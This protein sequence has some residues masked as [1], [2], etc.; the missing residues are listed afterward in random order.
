[1]D[2]TIDLDEELPA[3]A[4]PMVEVAPRYLTGSDAKRVAQVIFGSDAAFYEQRPSL[5]DEEIFS[6]AEI[7]AK[8]E[9]WQTW[10]DVDYLT[11]LFGDDEAAQRDAELVKL[12]IDDYTERYASAPE[13]DLRV[14][15][16]WTLKTDSAYLYDDAQLETWDTSED[17]MSIQAEVE[18]DGIPYRFTV[19][20]RD[21]ADFQLNNIYAAI[22]D[23]YGPSTIGW[24]ES[25]AKLTRTEKPDQSQIAAIQ[26]KAETWLAQMDLGDWSVD[27]CYLVTQTYHGTPEYYVTVTATPVLHSAV[28]LRQPNISTPKANPAY[29]SHY[30]MT[31]ATFQ[32]APGGELIN[33]QITS[34]I[35][36]AQ[37]VQE[38]VATLS[39]EDLLEQA[40]TQLTQT[41]P[42]SFFWPQDLVE[43]YEEIFGEEIQCTVTA[44]R[45]EYGLVRIK[46]PDS[47]DRYNYVPALML[48]GDAEYRGR[49]TGTVYEQYSS[50][51]NQPYYLLCLNANDGSSIPLGE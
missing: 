51:S 25:F 4:L 41:E 22:S 44:N 23:V 28:A 26:A 6:K 45:A 49:D 21:G 15:C 38:A 35:D 12:F 34:T 17:C 19:S 40:R 37:V 2:I 47:D 3:D 8:L 10:L 46:A 9:K 14:P 1:M 29:A 27:Q 7:A 42:G 50:I 36:V 33:M 48:T 18:M 20:V 32:F 30:Y 39:L 13:A 43:S 31:D 5:S 11:E 16:Q 24:D